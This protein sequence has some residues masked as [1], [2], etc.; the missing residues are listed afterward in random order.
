MT[1]EEERG[2]FATAL[3]GVEAKTIIDNALIVPWKV[4]VCISRASF[5]HETA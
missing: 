3:V 1:P 5:P 2:R 4:S